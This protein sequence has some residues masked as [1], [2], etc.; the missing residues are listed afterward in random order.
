LTSDGF[1][2]DA[3]NYAPDGF[4]LAT[5][6]WQGSPDSSIYVLNANDGSLIRSFAAHPGA[7]NLPAY[8]PDG[9]RMAFVRSGGL[10]AGIYMMRTDGSG[11]FRVVDRGWSPVWSPDGTHLAYVLPVGTQAEL[12]MV[13]T[14]GNNAQRI[15]GGI[16]MERIAWGP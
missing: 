9:G 7:D 14:N 16:A 2:Y 8:S 3:P 12:W 4:R 15:L 13:D 5:H 11:V 10:D 6:S 1:I